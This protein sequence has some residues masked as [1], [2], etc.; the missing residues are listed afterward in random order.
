M[1]GHNGQSAPAIAER[2]LF[3]DRELAQTLDHNK[4]APFVRVVTNWKGLTRVETAQPLQ[5]TLSGAL[6]KIPR[7]DKKIPKKI[8]RTVGLAEENRS[9]KVLT[10]E[11]RFSQFSI[12]LLFVSYLNEAVC[13]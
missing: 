13:V 12:F 3:Q 6:K 2:E 11:D 7:P 1:L 5:R 4:G 10:E 8:L 9:L